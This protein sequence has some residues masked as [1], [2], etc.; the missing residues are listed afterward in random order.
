MA[1]A[2]CAAVLPNQKKQ[3]CKIARFTDAPYASLSFPLAA[4]SSL[5]LSSLSNLFKRMTLSEG[6]KEVEVR[7]CKMWAVIWVSKNSPTEF[8]DGCPCFHIFV[9]S[10]VVVLRWISAK[11]LWGQTLLRRFCEVLSVWIYSSELMLWTLGVMSTK[12]TAYAS[13]LSKRNSGHDFSRWRSGLKLL[14]K[15][16]V[17]CYCSTDHLSVCRSKWCCNVPSS[18]RIRDKKPSPPAL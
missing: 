4:T 6:F 8:C 15:R 5:T 17:G 12:N 11:F 9:W 7:G 2:A 18:V 14:L 1:K 10:C 16:S 3:C 13:P